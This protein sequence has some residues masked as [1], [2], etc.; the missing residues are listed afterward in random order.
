VSTGR[1]EVREEAPRGPVRPPPFSHFSNPFEDGTATRRDPQEVIAYTFAAL[2]SWAWDRG[3]G[4]EA[5]ET[6]FEFASR[7]GLEFDELNEAFRRF[8]TLSV[9]SEYSE[10][11]LPADALKHVETFWDELVHG[12]GVVAVG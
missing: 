12:T 10:A 11:P 3:H 5:M 7:L 2:D 8:T 9:R 1:S 4:R 6:P